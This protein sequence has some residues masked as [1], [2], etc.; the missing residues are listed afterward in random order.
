LQIKR[1]MLNYVCQ[2][3][4]FGFATKAHKTELGK[5]LSQLDF[6]GRQLIDCA[7]RWVAINNC[8]QGSVPAP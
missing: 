5:A 7:F 1:S 8:F 4:Y 2:R 6:K 3:D